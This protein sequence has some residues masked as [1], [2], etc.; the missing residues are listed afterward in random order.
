M[1]WGIR[2]GLFLL[3]CA[4]IYVSVDEAQIWWRERF[5]GRLHIQVLHCADIQY[6]IDHAMPY[7]VLHLPRGVCVVSEPLV[8]D[9][10]RRSL[11]LNRF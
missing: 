4:L 1:R 8:I 11:H 7:T 5:D 3:C 10:R 6:A 9:D 2:G